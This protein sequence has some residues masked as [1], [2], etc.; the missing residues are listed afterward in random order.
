[1]STILKALKKL[2]QEQEGQRRASSGQA[3][4]GPSTAVGSRASALRW[5]TAKW[6]RRGLATL[7]ILV[8]AGTS[9]YYYQ[10]SHY[11]RR[12]RMNQAEQR[13]DAGP[14]ERRPAVSAVPGKPLQAPAVLP[15]QP[16]A[17]LPPGA[18]ARQ[19]GSQALQPENRAEKS[20][21][22]SPSQI[23]VRDTA[24]GPPA[25][26][27][28]PME[29]IKAAPQ[30]QST[31]TAP[32]PVGPQQRKG[33]SAAAPAPVPQPLPS[34]EPGREAPPVARDPAGSSGGG[35]YENAILLTDGRLKVQALA[36]SPV[37]EDRMAVINT[38]ILHE[39]DKVDGFSVLAIR[40]DD[41]VVREK[42]VVYRVPF[43]FP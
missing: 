12:S 14:V 41:V 6:I 23:P 21:P 25:Q 11:A 15:Q 19:T 24:A 38:R 31:A 3:Y 39:G 26:R 28:P 16:A 42:G 29:V 30:P 5:G 4:F 32:V 34:Q 2:E 8:L 43:G 35:A 33:A 27:Q 9:Y 22:P 40:R 18:A 20:R 10:Q 13:G 37:A 17:K 36:W 1:V 7:L